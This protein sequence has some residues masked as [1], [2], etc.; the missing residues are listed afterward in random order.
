MKNINYSYFEK[1]SNNNLE[2]FNHL[3]ITF[4][5]SSS[6]GF[7]ELQKGIQ[8]MSE[9][10][11]LDATHKLR[12]TYSYFGDNSIKDKIQMIEENVNQGKDYSEFSFLYYRLKKEVKE[13]HKSVHERI[14]QIHKENKKNQGYD[15]KLAS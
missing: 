3:L 2:T 15:K 14:V 8:E 11:I 9:S 5:M 12:S 4:L 13:F 6:C 1:I 7:A 10:E